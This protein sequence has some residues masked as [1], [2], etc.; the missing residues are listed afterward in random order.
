MFAPIDQTQFGI[1][2]QL[3][4]AVKSGWN[5]GFGSTQVPAQ[6]RQV[7]KRNEFEKKCG[8]N[9]PISERGLAVQHMICLPIYVL[10]RVTSQSAKKFVYTN[11]SLG[12]AVNSQNIEL[13]IL[14]AIGSDRSQHSRPQR[15]R[16]YLPHCPDLWQPAKLRKQKNSHS[17]FMPAVDK[18]RSG[19][20]RDPRT[21]L[22]HSSFG[23]IHAPKT[24]FEKVKHSEVLDSVPFE[25]VEA[26]E[27]RKI[28]RSGPF[29]KRADPIASLLIRYEQSPETDLINAMCRAS[30]NRQFDGTVWAT[31]Q[32]QAEQLLS[33]FSLV[34]SGII[35]KCLLLRDTATPSRSPIRLVLALLRQICR[36]PRTSKPKLGDHTVLYAMQAL[37]HFG[38]HIDR[39]VSSRYST[40]L[41]GQ[42]DVSKAKFTVLLSIIQALS[43]R[44]L[45]HMSTNKFLSEATVRLCKPSLEIDGDS[46]FGLVSAA[47]R[48]PLSTE[49]SDLL[50]VCKNLLL[51]PKGDELIS[52]LSL[53]QLSG[54]AHA[55]SRMGPATSA[56][57][58][59]IFTRVGDELTKCQTEQ[60]TAR[61]LAVTINAYGTA[62]VLHSDLTKRLRTLI[63]QE[64]ANQFD[65][66][67]TA[68]IV[69]GLSR[70]GIL[71]KFRPVITR[72]E[73][74]V[75]E[76]DIHSLSKLISAVG[77]AGLSTSVYCTRLGEVVQS[78][79]EWTPTSLDSVIL[80]LNSVV[81][82]PGDHANIANTLLSVLAAN[83]SV[84]EYPKLGNLL[85][86]FATT[87]L[88]SMAELLQAVMVQLRTLP[89]TDTLSLPD[90]VKMVH[91]L[92]YSDVLTGEDIACILTLLRDRALGIKSLTYRP[93]TRL[94][95]ALVRSGIYDEDILGAVDETL[96][97]LANTRT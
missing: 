88:P 93:L 32:D 34:D 25:M 71:R 84:I 94:A 29:N 95:A 28:L 41:V 24:R 39:S 53:I 1:S 75:G 73:D 76:F 55:Y 36:S 14:G 4:L 44:N 49:S 52:G 69:Y 61:T 89:G 40:R 48:F 59:D 81:A 10:G 27:E 92:S 60:W 74:L 20:Q 97:N 35:L 72:S 66:L 19:I 96:A 42:F 58:L 90:L 85:F 63:T 38:T 21:L 5:R 77:D 6:P 80:A 12:V 64:M 3:R 83:T 18:L 68:M 47:A 91:A 22:H 37:N 9:A 65:A 11:Q 33:S 86:S 16:I 30:A 57:H 56:G 79:T 50:G 82:H 67:Q 45:P 78:T 62:A 23:L 51:D 26:L 87:R 2:R 70:L 43:L 17:A 8:W 13:N 54:V 15:T 46:L 7:S 31:F